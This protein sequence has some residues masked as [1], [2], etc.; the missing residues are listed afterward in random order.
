[1]VWFFVNLLFPLMGCCF[2]RPDSQNR[3]HAVSPRP[4]VP[5]FERLPAPHRE[6]TL[7]K[8]IDDICHQDASQG[9]CLKFCVK[10]L[11]WGSILLVQIR[12]HRTPDARLEKFVCPFLFRGQTAP[13]EHDQNSLTLK[14]FDAA[15]QMW[16][17]GFTVH[18][19]RLTFWPVFLFQLK[20]NCYLQNF[21]C[22][23]NTK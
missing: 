23:E 20:S 15:I 4:A 19:N 3:I 12:L 6:R 11:V 2:I 10:L 21:R 18:W 5:R 22:M 7:R 8:P 14:T 17:F 13:D 9:V 16:R 1:M